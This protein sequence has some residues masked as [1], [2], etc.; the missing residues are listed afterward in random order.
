MPTP[1]SRA[2]QATPG[3]AIPRSFGVMGGV[4]VRRP[5]CWRNRVRSHVHPDCGPRGSRP[6]QAARSTRLRKI[7]DVLKVV[8]APPTRSPRARAPA[9][10]WGRPS[11]SYERSTPSSSSTDRCSSGL[12]LASAATGSLS[13]RTT[14]EVLCRSVPSRCSSSLLAH[15]VGGDVGVRE[16]VSRWSLRTSGSERSSRPPT[17]WSPAS[18]GRRR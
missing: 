15:A 6:R 4:P 5:T 13:W 18:G 3:F 14:A 16:V 1:D 8:D 12:A 2:W 10:T 9:V 17:S 11:G 7:G